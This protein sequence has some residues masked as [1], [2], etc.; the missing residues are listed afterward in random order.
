MQE[1]EDVLQ[2]LVVLVR[3]IAAQIVENLEGY[4]RRDGV[5]AALAGPRSRQMSAHVGPARRARP[6]RLFREARAAGGGGRPDPPRAGA[7]RR[8]SDPRGRAARALAA[9]A[10]LQ[11]SRVRAG[12]KRLLEA[13]PYIVAAAFL[14]AFLGKPFHIDDANFI[15]YARWTRAHP[16]DLYAGGATQSNPPGNAYLLAAITA[17][18]GERE[19]AIHLCLLPLA[20]AGLAG[21]RA[22]AAGLGI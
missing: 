20:L 22:L 7:H 5:R 9:S 2:T 17:L 3:A 8:Q 16:W 11:D 19:W 1:A 18:V 10:P 15:Q 14:L 13:A 6:R 12:M 4:L 21:T